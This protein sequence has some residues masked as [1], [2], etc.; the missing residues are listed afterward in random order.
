MKERGLEARLRKGLQHPRRRQAARGVRASAS[1]SST[2]ALADAL[3]AAFA[4]GDAVLVEQFIRPV[5]CVWGCGN[6]GAFPIVRSRPLGARYDYETKYTK[7]ASTHIMPA[8]VGDAATKDPGAGKRTFAACG[9]RGVARVDMML[10]R[11]GRTSSN[12]PFPGMTELSSCRTQHAMNSRSFVEAHLG[13]DSNDESGK[14][15]A[16]KKDGR[17]ALHQARASLETFF[18][19]WPAPSCLP[20]SSPPVFTLRACS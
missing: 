3:K 5:G 11:R 4:Y 14:G 1:T 16:W 15:S 13:A 6:T 2:K 10:P 18:S 9:C 17:T 12:G 19:C 8:P 7:G 20:L